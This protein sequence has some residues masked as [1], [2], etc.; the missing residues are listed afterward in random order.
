MESKELA[1]LCV[2]AAIDKK[3]EHSLLFEVGKMGAF[4][5]YFLVTSGAS[6]RQ[7]TAIA[8]EIKRV[9]KEH[10]L[11]NPAMEGLDEGRWVLIDFGYIV[12]HVFQEAIREFYDLES[13][14]SNAPRVNI[15]TD[16]YTQTQATT[17]S[18]KQSHVPA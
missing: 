11:P 2:K 13:L 7:V 17:A 15:P 1:L 6:D 12:I 4:T 14:W 5:D 3:A 9:A 10:G 16:F 8:N 18:S